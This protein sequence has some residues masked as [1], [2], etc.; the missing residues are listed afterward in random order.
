VTR[1]RWLLLGALVALSLAV[2]GSAS[3]WL[4]IPDLVVAQ[5]EQPASLPEEARA[6]A[7]QVRRGETANEI[8]RRLGELRLIRSPLLFR[9][10][11]GYYGVETRLEAGEYELHAGMS[12]T[13]IISRLHR[14]LVRTTLITAP[15]GWS[16]AEVA[17]HFERQGAVREAEMLAAA[18]RRSYGFAFLDELPEGLGL[19]GYLFPDSYRVQPGTTAEELVA[20]MLR[21]FD[22]RVTAGMRQQA[23]DQ[24]LSLHGLV[25]LASIVEREAM[26]AEERPL[27]AG[28]FLNRLSRRMP[29][30]A[31]PTVQYALA[32]DPASVRRWGIWKENLFREDLD[33]DT[34]YNTYR[35]TGLP[36]G[37][38]ANPGLASIIAVLNASQTDYLYFVAQ[39][40]GSHLFA[41]TLEEHNRNVRQRRS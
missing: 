25:T 14:G 36:P 9:L 19:E 12:P 18:S 35:Y 20:L 1:R 26:V 22:Q 33:L 10:L 2:A 40:D 5:I 23:A 17:R 31:D 34:P 30:Q 8:A 3:F 21:T 4:L 39:G 38:I 28:V 32:R 16:I 29:L 24:G 13:E 37:P 6:V 7:F 15:E 11:V 27:I 41:R